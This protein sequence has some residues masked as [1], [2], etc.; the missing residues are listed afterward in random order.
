MEVLAAVDRDALAVLRPAAGNRHVHEPSG[1]RQDAVKRG[2][3]LMAHQRARTA[4]QNGGH[5]PGLPRQSGVAD[6]VDAVLD[7]M[8]ASRAD[9]VAHGVGPIAQAPKLRR[10]DHTVLL[11]SEHCQLSITSSIF[12]VLLTSFLDVSGHGPKLRP[13]ERDVWVTS[14]TP[15]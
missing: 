14:V 5:E 12:L 2:R 10:G 11:R 13:R 7:A 15:A 8:Q 9:P 4:G 1:A 6:R 3:R